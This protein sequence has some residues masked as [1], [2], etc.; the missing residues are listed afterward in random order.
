M[1]RL[2]VVGYDVTGSANGRGTLAE[3]LTTE[4]VCRN[5]G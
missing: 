4:M 5:M 2:E 3:P 1:G